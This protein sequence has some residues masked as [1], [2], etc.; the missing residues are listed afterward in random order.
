MVFVIG[1]LKPNHVYIEQPRELRGTK[2]GHAHGAGG[3]AATEPAEFGETQ[4]KNAPQGARQ[5]VTPFGPI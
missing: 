3:R 4:Q 5:M 1:L 2:W